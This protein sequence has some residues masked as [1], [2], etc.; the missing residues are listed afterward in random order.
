[1]YEVANGHEVVAEVSCV[2]LSIRRSMPLRFPAGRCRFR[3][4]SQWKWIINARKLSIFGLARVCFSSLY[5]TRRHRGRTTSGPSLVSIKR[6]ITRGSIVRKYQGRLNSTPTARIM[7]LYTRRDLGDSMNFYCLW[8]TVLP[9]Q[10]PQVNIDLSTLHVKDL[11]H[12]CWTMSS[13][14]LRQLGIPYFS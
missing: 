9:C 2:L 7:Q 12:N 11:R 5:V 6:M 4:T 10:K 13:H 1:M 8:I 3:G 14:P